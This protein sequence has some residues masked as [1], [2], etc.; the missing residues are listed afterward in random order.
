MQ[1]IKTWNG[2]FVTDIDKRKGTNKKTLFLYSK[3]KIRDRESI[4]VI[5]Q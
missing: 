4:L 1:E 2:I 5:D 3:D